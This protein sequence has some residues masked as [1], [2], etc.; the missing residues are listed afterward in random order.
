LRERAWTELARLV[1][2]DL[3]RT[4]YEVAPLAAVPEL[5][6][7]LLAGQIRGRMVIDVHA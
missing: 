2:L 4:I 6:A 5:A 3:L 7:R 1:D